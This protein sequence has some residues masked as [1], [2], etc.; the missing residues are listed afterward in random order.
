MATIYE[1]PCRK[2]ARD[3]WARFVGIPITE[4]YDAEFEW[5]E[6]RMLDLKNELAGPRPKISVAEAVKLARGNN[7]PPSVPIKFAESKT[8][9]AEM[10][11][12]LKACHLQMLQSN[13]TSEYAEEANQ[14]AIKALAKS[15]DFCAARDVLVRAAGVGA[16]F[17][18]GM[19]FGLFFL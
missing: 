11:E 12:A 18:F 3:V 2:A 4:P 17:V 19:A 15:E 6:D 10:Y 14:M 1:H 8:I 9:N 7:E 13:N 16:A 5:L